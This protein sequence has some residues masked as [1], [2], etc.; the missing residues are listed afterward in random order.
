MSLVAEA[1]EIV[2]SGNSC[3]ATEAFHSLVSTFKSN[4]E[5]FMLRAEQR[6]KELETLV[7]VYSFCGQVCVLSR[8]PVFFLFYFL[9]I[10]T[11]NAPFSLSDLS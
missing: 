6:Q 8:L 2:G 10:A 11:L 3:P 9:A 7:H 1:E 5:E 4:V